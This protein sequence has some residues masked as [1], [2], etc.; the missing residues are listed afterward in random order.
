M[1][2]QA[3]KGTK[4]FLPRE[5]ELRTKMREIIEK[6]YKNFGFN[7]ISTPI[8]EDIENLMNSNGG[9]NLKLI[10]KFII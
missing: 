3:V 8:I 6:T 7:K 9:E 10:F 5:E 1:K 2:T 4:D